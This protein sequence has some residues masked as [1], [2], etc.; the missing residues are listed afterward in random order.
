MNKIERA[1]RRKK[2]VRAKIFGTSEVPRLSVKKTNKH[3][4]SQIIDDTKGKTL[5]FV[6]TLDKELKKELK[7]SSNCAA[8][9]KVG[10]LLAKRALEVGIKKVV[11][12]RGS[13]KY[14]GAIQNLAEAARKGG[15]E[16]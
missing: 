4:Y 11:F 9:E 13:R 3:I 15:L 14:H 5:L 16:F 1:Q 7:N 10:V 2:R 6:S 12:D 8:A